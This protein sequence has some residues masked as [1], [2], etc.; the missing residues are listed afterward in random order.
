MVGKEKRREKKLLE[1]AE[2]ILEKLKMLDNKLASDILDELR[3]RIVD[4]YND[5]H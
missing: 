5:L 3:T 4:E 1:E 2:L